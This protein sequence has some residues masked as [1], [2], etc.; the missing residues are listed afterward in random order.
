M[1]TMELE[2]DPV[3]GKPL[4]WV[5]QG[6]DSRTLSFHIPDPGLF[7]TEAEAQE[8]CRRFSSETCV[9]GYRSVT[10]GKMHL[11]PSEL[12]PPWRREKE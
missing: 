2:T 11:A 8:Y 3:S 12:K 9:Y 6:F 1:Q 7:A 4:L 10:I 5:V